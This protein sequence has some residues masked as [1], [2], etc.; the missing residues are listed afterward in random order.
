M[1]CIIALAIGLISIIIGI[2]LGGWCYLLI[3][4]PF[5]A[6]FTWIGW[7]R[8]RQRTGKS[9]KRWL[10][11]QLGWGHSLA[12]L[13]RRLGMDEGS[14]RACIPCYR[15]VE[16]PKRCG[17]MR[18][19]QVPDPQTMAMQRTILHR[20]LGRLSAHPAAHAYERNRSIVTQA[21]LHTGKALILKMDV[22]DFFPSTTSKR[23]ERYFRGIGWNRS[24]A[25]LLVRLTCLNGG[26]PQGA[27][28]S[29]RLANLV[30]FQLDTV[31]SGI[32]SR[33]KGTY[34]RYADDITIS[35]PED[36]PKKSRG[37]ITGV[38]R[39]FRRVGYRIHGPPKLGIFRSHQRQLVT[40]LVVNQGIHL[41]R[42]RRRWLR[43]VLHHQRT[44]QAT[45]ITKAQ[46]AGWVAYNR[47]IEN[48]TEKK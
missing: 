47:M 40:G 32:A 31:I 17:G 18:K 23:I 16:I 1:G 27:P 12:E 8:F 29:P 11:A 44:Q 28:T 2:I 35:F 10:W 22:I 20:L 37:I 38:R 48:G 9:L 14:L 19:L 4:A 45:T 25:R 30:N 39:A 43:A 3:P 36:W 46:I 33:F 5:L 15:E 24:A 6:L 13:A 42:E 34:T 41:P 26:L 7:S 21:R